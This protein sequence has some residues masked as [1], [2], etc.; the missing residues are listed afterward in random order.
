MASGELRI[1]VVFERADEFA[2]RLS[3]LI[4]EARERAGPEGLAPPTLAEDLVIRLRAQG[5]LVYA[6][7]L[8]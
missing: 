7:D 3:G 2:A 4:A 1:V 6:E 8:E 5:V